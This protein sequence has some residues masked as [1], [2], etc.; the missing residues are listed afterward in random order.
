MPY[1][2]TAERKT[3]TLASTGKGEFVACALPLW[4]PDWQG[5]KA[6]PAYGAG[7]ALGFRSEYEVD[8][9]DRAISFC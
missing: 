4:G 9:E 7:I 6:S 2:D 5:T 8:M 1:A 3:G